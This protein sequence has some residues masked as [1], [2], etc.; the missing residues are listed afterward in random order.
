MFE[1]LHNKKLIGKEE[2]NLD[3]MS[4]RDSLEDLYPLRGREM[5]QLLEEETGV[6]KTPLASPPQPP[7]LL[8]Q[9]A[10]LRNCWFLLK[11]P[12]LHLSVARQKV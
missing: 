6:V 11:H 2:E 12:T 5:K 1:I 3:P 9:A 8:L 7:Q 4:T 10:L